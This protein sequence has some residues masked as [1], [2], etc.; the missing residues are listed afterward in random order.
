[1]A[2]VSR[3]VK[4]VVEASVETII[5]KITELISAVPATSEP[6]SSNPAKR[7]AELA[8]IAKAK[9]SAISGLAALPP[10]PL[11]LLTIV[12]DLVAIWKLQQQLVVDIAAAYGR[13]GNLTPE[14]MLYCLF[15]H[16]AGHVFRDVLV[17]VGE[18]WLVRRATLR[19]MQ[20]ILRRLGYS[21]TQRIISKAASR[22]VPIVGAVGI[23]GYAW[24][25]TSRV[26]KTAVEYFSRGGIAPDFEYVPQPDGP[27]GPG[28]GAEA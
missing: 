2:E 28:Q 8:F 11:G 17:R 13:Q 4:A 12:P 21:V 1:V 9:A 24:Y 6:K 10:G 14:E 16:A 3:S 7:A 20:Q 23:A 26:A 22:W 15:R 19:V 5:E 18:R 25:D 27:A